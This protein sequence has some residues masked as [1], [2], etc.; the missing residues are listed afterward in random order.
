MYVHVLLIFN[1]CRQGNYE[2]TGD[3]DGDGDRKTGDRV[4]ARAA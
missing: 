3:G 1:F 4:V 2:L